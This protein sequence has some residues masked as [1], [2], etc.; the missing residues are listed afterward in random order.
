MIKNYNKYN[1]IVFEW[2]LWKDDGGNWLTPYGD[3]TEEKKRKKNQHGSMG[4]EQ[5]IS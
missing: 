2:T 5:L 1:K 4:D 3:K